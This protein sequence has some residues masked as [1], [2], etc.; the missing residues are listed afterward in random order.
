LNGPEPTASGI[1]WKASVFAIR[2][3]IMNG[4]LLDNLPSALSNSGKGA[5]NAIVKLLSSSA[6]IETTASI[7][8]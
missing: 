1:C 3:G 2:S 5:F 6:L 7:I 4:T 8:F